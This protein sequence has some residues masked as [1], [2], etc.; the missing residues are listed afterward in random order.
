M[1]PFLGLV[2]QLCNYPNGIDQQ[3]KSNFEKFKIA[4]NGISSILGGLFSSVIDTNKIKDGIK[5]L[6]GT[7]EKIFDKQIK[8]YLQL[9]K[10]KESFKKALSNLEGTETIKLIFIDELDRCAPNFAVR[11]LETVKHYFNAEN[12]VFVVLIDKTILAQNIQHFYGQNIDA[13]RYLSRF[14]DFELDL[15]LSKSFYEKLVKQNLG[16]ER[17]S[18]LLL[19]FIGFLKLSAREINKVCFQLQHLRSITSIDRPEIAILLT[20]KIADSQKFNQ[21]IALVENGKYISGDPIS[22][23]VAD[24][25]IFLSIFGLDDKWS[26]IIGDEH[27]KMSFCKLFILL[28]YKKHH[29]NELNKPIITSNIALDKFIK[30]ECVENSV[31]DQEVFYLEQIIKLLRS[32]SHDLHH[33]A[34]LK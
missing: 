14:F 7:D 10:N 31:I 28:I 6:E 19:L 20:L 33:V 27:I 5:E 12:T 3:A 22:P 11:F 15:P 8:T 32:F 16:D 2:G 17:F 21:L 26:D 13:E 4:A 9:K 30:T 25:K 18:N 1:N 24:F 34:S 23:I 29:L